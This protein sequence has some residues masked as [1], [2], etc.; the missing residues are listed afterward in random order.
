MKLRILDCLCGVLAVFFSVFAVFM[1]AFFFEV[2]TYNVKKCWGITKDS[3]KDIPKRFLKDIF[4]KCSNEWI[5]SKYF[6]YTD[7]LKKMIFG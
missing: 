5:S 4:L 3:H 7:D 6:E 2:E 1:A